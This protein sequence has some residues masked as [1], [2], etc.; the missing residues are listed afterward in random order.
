MRRKPELMQLEMGMST[1]RYFPASG[2][3]GFARSFVSGNSRVPWPPPMMTQRTL[4]VLSD[5]RPVC[6][7]KFR[8]GEKFNSD[9]AAGQAAGKILWQPGWRGSNCFKTKIIQMRPTSAAAMKRRK[10]AAPLVAVC[11]WWSRGA[12]NLFVGDDVRSL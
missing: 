2:T 9:F 6:G 12:G 3:A 1:S 7:I 5:W 10:Y 8:R 11:K 4:L